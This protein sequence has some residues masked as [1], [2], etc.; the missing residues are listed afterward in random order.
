MSFLVTEKGRKGFSLMELL[1]VIFI[2]SLIYF[3]GFGGMEKREKISEILTPLTLKKILTQNPLFARK[4]TLICIN[5]C[6]S[7]YFREDI[8]TPFKPYNGKVNLA[9]AKVYTL[10]NNN[11]LQKMDYGRYQDKKICFKFNIYRNGSTSQLIVHTKKGIYFLPA[12]FGEPT[13]VTSLQ[14]AKS[15]WLAHA[16]DLSRRGDFY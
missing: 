11:N 13:E 8:S 16:H 12:Y 10:S 9:D 1:I 4:G 3:L 5:N 14:Q 15:L 7:C 2:I 6:H